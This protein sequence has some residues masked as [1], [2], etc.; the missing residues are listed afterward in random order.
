MSGGI[1]DAEIGKVRP[2]TYV[3]F[4]SASDSQI[5]TSARGLT[6]IPL[7]AKYG[8][9]GTIVEV[10]TNNAS[11]LYSELG[12]DVYD[13]TE[14]S[15]LLIREALKNSTIV[16]VYILNGGTKATVTTGA[17][18][19]TAKY[20]GIRGNSYKIVIATNVLG[21]FDVSLYLDT[22]KLEEFYQV[23]TVEELIAIGSA[24]VTFTGEGELE[25]TAGVSLATG[26]STES[27]AEDLSTFLDALENIK[28]NAVAFPFTLEDSQFALIKSKIKYLKDKLGRTG[29][30]VVAKNSGDY[31]A[32][33]NVTNGVVL[34]DGVELSAEEATAWVAGVT[35]G[36]LY[37]QSNTYKVYDGAVSVN[38]LYNNEEAEA[39]IKNGEFFFS[40]SN[41][42]D[43]VVE[44]DIN[45]LVNTEGKSEDHKKN[46]FIRVVD[47]LLEKLQ[48]EFPP[49]RF[50]NTTEDWSRIEGLGKAILKTFE[51]DGAITDVDYDN[52]FVV[53]RTKSVG[54]AT[55]ITI[56]IKPVD[57][58]EKI[59]ITVRTS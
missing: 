22:L 58:A 32:I 13:K 24:Y 54:D 31:E 19:V 4:V 44:Y 9:K 21:G 50:N 27:T 39:A 33:I 2:G 40:Y 48:E 49:A 23:K 8:K 7:V 17:L 10:T 59:Y 11:K 14:R 34:S 18:T 6:V 57:S 46:R 43:V 1:F 38:G 35:A 30:F 47:T 37:N 3:N 36:A 25:E 45:S 26:T 51:E 20:E 55:Y 52:D 53:D 42:G 28:F 12:F 15:M 16:K 29:Q 41:N 5:E 56:A